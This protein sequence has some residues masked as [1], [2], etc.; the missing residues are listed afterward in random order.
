MQAILDQAK[1]EGKTDHAGLRAKLRSSVSIS[2][3]GHGNV[4]GRGG[5][6]FQDANTK[7]QNYFVK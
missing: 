6:L 3:R 5:K 7:N 4:L 2:R 1:E